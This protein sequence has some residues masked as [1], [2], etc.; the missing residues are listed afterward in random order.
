MNKDKKAKTA[1]RFMYC[2]IR[3]TEGRKAKKFIGGLNSQDKGAW[4]RILIK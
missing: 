1:D 4:K 2:I 3:F